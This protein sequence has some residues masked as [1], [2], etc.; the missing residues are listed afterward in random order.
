MSDAGAPAAGTDTL[1]QSAQFLGPRGG[2]VGQ[3]HTP[4]LV[5]SSG[6]ALPPSPPHVAWPLPSAAP[7]TTLTRARDSPAGGPKPSRPTLSETPD[8]PGDAV[9][10]AVLPAVPRDRPCAVIECIAKMRSRSG[11]STRRHSEQPTSLPNGRNAKIRAVCGGSRERVAAQRS[12]RRSHVDATP[13][14]HSGQPRR[15]QSQALEVLTQRR[16]DAAPGVDSTPPDSPPH[17]G[18]A[19][20]APTCGAA[21]APEQ[22][23]AAEEATPRPV[24]VVQGRVKGYRMPI[25]STCRPDESR[26][27][28]DSSDGPWPQGPLP[29]DAARSPSAISTTSTTST[30][31][32]ASGAAAPHCSSPTESCF[33]CALPFDNADLLDHHLI[34]VH[35]YVANKFPCGF[36]EHGYCWRPNRDRH[37]SSAHGI[38]PEGDDLL[39]YAAAPALRRYVCENCGKVFSDASNLQRH[40]RTHHA[41][42]R[43]HACAECGK[44][45][46]TASGLKQHA[47][48]HSSVKP[49]R[50][51][52]CLKAYTQFSNLCRHKRMH[53]N[54]RTRVQCQ[55]CRQGFSS[56]NSLA[57]HKR[58][59]EVSAE[60]PEPERGAAPPDAA[61]APPA[62][63]AAEPP[64]AMNNPAPNASLLLYPP[65]PFPA[66]PMFPAP[67]HYANPFLA[68]TLLF[69]KARDA[70][71]EPD[72]AAAMASYPLLPP[73]P[74]P[75]RRANGDPADEEWERKDGGPPSP[76]EDE[77][78]RD[79]SA[80]ASP[81]GPPAELPLDLRVAKRRWSAGE[82]GGA[83][84]P[85]KEDAAPPSAAA[86]GDKL[87]EAPPMAYPRPIHPIFLEAMYR[88]ERPAQAVY[89]SYS[90]DERLLPQSYGPHRGVAFPFLGP[91]PYDLLRPP[92]LPNFGK[93]YHEVLG[94]AA[95]AAGGA[96]GGGG[97]GGGGGGKSRGDRYSCRFCGKVFPRSAN[98][99]RHLRTHTGE[100]PYKCKYCERSFSI[101]SNLQRH[102]RN[103]HNK[104]K[105]FKCPLC[106]RCFGQQTNLDRHLKKHESGEEEGGPSAD[107]PHP[108]PSPDSPD[109]NED[110]YFDEIRSFMGKVTY[111]GDSPLMPSPLPTPNHLS[112]TAA[113]SAPPPPPPPP[114]P[115]VMYAQ[116]P[117]P[118]DPESELSGDEAAYEVQASP[119]KARPEDVSSPPPAPAEPIHV[120]S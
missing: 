2:Q 97:G 37:R 115:A 52:V 118:E 39:A 48:I 9:D 46:A 61:A 4:V 101:S 54:C 70:A 27:T 6:K 28:W 120:G 111:G 119:G 32:T 79:L 26:R 30:K 91:R 49:F 53:A 78:P 87:K 47:H 25:P 11:R 81:C 64:A 8:Q 55:S 24:A 15:L 90:V 89:S 19:P 10:P 72:A 117:Y 51:E 100:Q 7:P 94:G 50:C 34:S 84:P 116:P 3:A 58:F 63:T 73:A 112:V 76:P 82:K 16:V 88:L 83:A 66:F 57:K 102:V 77:G 69:A 23:P 5:C 109:S 105:P 95:A 107:G 33:I 1:S 114:P 20:A 42:A 44:T 104:E 17:P 43:S 35:K 36:C 18:A 92:A 93:P 67:P 71:A 45:F 103:I 74:P 56:L 22:Q 85:P 59:C 38:F 75:P 108:P 110:A 13:A 41:G 21:A 40:I 113:A 86:P 96:P 99:T 98:L 80:R 12:E 68:S 31:S 65:R 60:E 62:T 14:P 106:D 29:E